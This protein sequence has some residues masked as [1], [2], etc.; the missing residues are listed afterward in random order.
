MRRQARAAALIAAA[1]SVASVAH[2]YT[3]DSEVSDG[4]HESITQDALRSVRSAGL[5]PALQP[6][7]GDD[8]ALIDDV[9]YPIDGDMADLAAVALV[10]GNR[11]V[12]LHGNAPDD[13]DQLAPVHGAPE[14]Q[15][16]HCLRRPGDDEPD[17]SATAVQACHDL[18]LSRVTAA[19]AGLDEN[20]QPD[21]SRRTTMKIS[22]DLRGS[23]DVS[24]PTFYLEMGRALH[25]VQD[26]FSHTWRSADQRRI[27]VV[28]NYS[29]VINSSYDEAK[30]GPP[31]SSALDECTG[32]DGFRSERLSLATTASA[33]LLSAVLDPSLTTDSERIAAAQ[34]VL[35]EYLSYEPGCSYDN[36]WCDARENEY[37][38]AKGCA[39]SA[40]GSG[41]ASDN[42]VGLWAIVPALAW[43]FR[44]RRRRAHGGRAAFALAFAASFWALPAHA[45]DAEAKAP[46]TAVCPAAGAE[47]LDVT[48]DSTEAP[49]PF[50]LGAYAAGGVALTR[51]AFAV[52]LGAR[53]R[54][55]PYW[56]VGVDG[57]YN[58]WISRTKKEVR[59]GVTNVYATLIHRIPLSFE[60]I[61][62]RTTLHLGISRMNF[63]LYGVP[64]GTV[65]PYVG[66]NLLG[67]DWELTR[68]LYLVVDPADVALP[69][70]QTSGV[71]FVYP[72]YR[73]TVGVQLG[74]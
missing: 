18:I 67:L 61:N 9:P 17:G 20:G 8:Q 38:D 4:C 27:T 68:S 25:A 12:D 48:P 69:I 34:S 58:P 45:Q 44:R 73:F 5:A 21:P 35:D 41:R 42:R 52:S 16:E 54:F 24:L 51:T 33:T 71:P 53:Y 40:P 13:L 74:A 72:Q 70:P 64:K 31:H 60:T 30:D 10:L 3:I 11:N 65:G 32:L 46:P 23:V 7:S 62:L 14:N 55:S 43:L 63:A 22:L 50:P 2:A 39:C 28:L 56:L 36:D 66:F 6:Q 19:L 57:E 1:S 37:R 15:P 49:P 59:S 47:P 29:E 26:G